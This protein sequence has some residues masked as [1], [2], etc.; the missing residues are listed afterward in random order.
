MPG[1]EALSSNQFYCLNF[2]FLFLFTRYSVMAGTPD[3][4]LEHLLETRTGKSCEATGI[5][6]NHDWYDNDDFKFPFTFCIP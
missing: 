4:I 3:K 2:L 5:A 6:Y 1:L